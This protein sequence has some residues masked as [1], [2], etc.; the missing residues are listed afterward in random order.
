MQ[1][2]EKFQV[3][4]QRH[5]K[6]FWADSEI[7]TSKINHSVKLVYL[8]LCVF[9]NQKTQSCYPRLETLAAISGVSKRSVIRAINQ[10]ERAHLISVTHS[11]G[12]GKSNEYTLLSTKG[13]NLA[14]ISSVLKGDFRRTK[15][16]TNLTI[17]GD[18]TAPPTILKEQTKEQNVLSIL[19]EMRNKFGKVK[20]AR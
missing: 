10:L 3:R 5:T 7:L 18:T 8:G 20:H 13:A 17:K 11:P 9:A 19:E 16:V 2:Q 1:E 12:R 6:W 4:D 14:L 15:K